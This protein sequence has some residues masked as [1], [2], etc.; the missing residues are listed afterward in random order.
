M[1]TMLALLLL[2]ALGL[3]GAARLAPATAADSPHAAVS[4]DAGEAPCPCCED[5]PTSQ[6]AC[7]KHC[8]CPAGLAPLAP[9]VS[10]PAFR[11]AR[12]RPVARVRLEARAPDP[13]RRPPRLVS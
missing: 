10:P 2:V 9:K 4:A 3:E 8:V 12:Q 5:G 1:R 13:P 6:P 11:T 7:G